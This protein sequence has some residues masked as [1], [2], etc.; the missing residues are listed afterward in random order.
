MNPMPKHICLLITVTL[1]L[2]LG[3]L[4]PQHAS[5]QRLGTGT[6]ATPQGNASGSQTGNQQSSSNQA[7]T[8]QE[9][10][11]SLSGIRGYTP[12]STGEER[13]FLLPSLQVTGYW[14]SNPYYQPGGSTEL[15]V[16]TG[17]WSLA[18]Q[19]IKRRSQFNLSYAGGEI[20]SS[21]PLPSNF[22]TGMGKYQTY[23]SFSFGYVYNGLRWKSILMD[24]FSFLPESSFGFPGFTGLPGFG[25]GLGIPNSPSETPLSNGLVPSQS[26]LTGYSR[27]ISNVSAAEADYSFTPRTSLSM[28]GSYG[29]LQ[30][31]SSGFYD[32]NYYWGS[33]GLN[34]LLTRRDQLGLSYAYENIGFPGM[35]QNIETHLAQISYGR[36]ITGKLS[37][38]LSAGPMLDI[39]SQPVGPSVT[40]VFASTSDSLR[41]L[42]RAGDLHLSYIRYTSPGSGVFLG[43]ETGEVDAGVS[44]RLLRRFYGSLDASY[45]QNKSLTGEGVVINGSKFNTVGGGA[46]LSTDLGER[47]SFF[48]SYQIQQQSSNTLA[49]GD[50][51]CGS[52]FVRNI[53]TVGINW[54]GPPILLH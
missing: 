3:L 9:S 28:S 34:H 36:R 26:I 25:P 53:A 45:A 40:K 2:W 47:V 6:P 23:Q 50:G 12:G 32:T 29:I 44:H 42:L 4:C 20:V 51:Q 13:S 11:V 52:S 35:S 17:A 46:T 31:I 39:I 1:I 5:A 33:I 16:G 30:Y 43:A 27:R 15:Y 48:M 22:G 14:D 49:C 37:L 10:T 8:L 19:R 21:R 54:H 7:R 41:Y 24:Q 18:L 38:K